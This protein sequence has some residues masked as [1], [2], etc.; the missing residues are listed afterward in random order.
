M[1]KKIAKHPQKRRRQPAH[2]AGLVLVLAGAL[3]VGGAQPGQACT[4]VLTGFASSAYAAIVAKV[5]ASIYAIT[6][7]F[8]SL[9]DPVTRYANQTTNNH[10]NEV[11][12]LGIMTDRRVATMSATGTAESR[13]RVAQEMVQPSRVACRQVMSQVLY[14]ET[15]PEYATQRVALLKPETD[16]SL[17]RPGTASER[18]TLAA[19]SQ[20]FQYRCSKYA[21]VTN[22]LIPAGVT[23]AGGDPA[24]IDMDTKPAQSIF[25][26][27]VYPDADRE[28]AAKD[29]IRMLIQV[30]PGDPLRGPALSRV[31]GQNLHVERMKNLT[32]MNLARG[33][34][35]DAVA[36][37]TKQTT[38]FTDG[39]SGLSRMERLRE[40]MTGR[41]NGATGL[42]VAAQMDQIQLAAQP[43]NANVQSYAARLAGQR[44]LLLELIRMTEQMVALEAVR[45]AVR[46]EENPAGQA[47]LAGRAIQ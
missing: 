29:T 25:E 45:L 22:M 11:G 47:T 14:K 38:A 46:V 21:D 8:A 32:R 28:L 2:R 37:R 10:Q 20:A 3:L 34:L 17:N 5:A 42:S 16:F 33:V 44:M 12:V 23:C 1:P 9:Y 15:W 39:R 13:L 4:P 41:T 24:Y 19:L 27:V 18:G 43:E 7:G 40:L 36:M 26:P 6:T 35:Q 30:A 31:D